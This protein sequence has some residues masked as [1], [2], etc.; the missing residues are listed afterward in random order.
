MDAKLIDILEERIV[1]LL[2]ELEALKAANAALESETRSLREE[3]TQIK[4]RVDELL[5]KLEGI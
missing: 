2:S 1:Q 4:A 3:R 5:A